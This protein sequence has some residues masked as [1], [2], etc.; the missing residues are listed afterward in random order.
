M[1]WSKYPGELG[2]TFE[3]CAGIVDK[4]LPLV[5]IAKEEVEEECGYRVPIENFE[6]VTSMR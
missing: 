5:E 2:M 4:D 1:D 6:K 3:L